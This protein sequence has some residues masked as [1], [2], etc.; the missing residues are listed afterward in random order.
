ML[1][2]TDHVVEGMFSEP[3]G[4]IYRR[5][6]KA[7]EV[8][9][10]VADTPHEVMEFPTTKYPMLPKIIQMQALGIPVDGKINV[11]RL[12]LQPGDSVIYVRYIPRKLGDDQLRFALWEIC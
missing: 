9:D 3:T 12:S 7:E 10:L 1:Y 6:I 4:E 5:R 8:A 11:G 2:I